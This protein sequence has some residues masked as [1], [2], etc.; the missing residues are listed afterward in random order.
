VQLSPTQVNAVH[1]CMPW[2]C[3]SKLEKIET[4]PGKVIF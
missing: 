3:A 2:A 4:Y 1:M